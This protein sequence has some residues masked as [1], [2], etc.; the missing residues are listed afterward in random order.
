LATSS[1]GTS[2]FGLASTDAEGMLS[3]FASPEV[4]KLIDQA[5][6]TADHDAR[7]GMYGRIQTLI[8]ESA[9]MTIPSFISY[10]DGLSNKVNGLT[11][12]PIGSL[13]GNDFANNAWLSE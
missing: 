10:V 5:S 1:S 12:L 13:N 8:Y 2:K 3:R 11:A 6:A 4:D 9:A 7:K